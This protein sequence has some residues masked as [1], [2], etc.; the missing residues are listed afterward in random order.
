ME[1][2]LGRFVVAVL[3][4][5]AVFALFGCG[6][7]GGSSQP[8]P[9][10]TFKASNVFVVVLEN[11]GFSSVIGNA[12]MP[13]L[14]SLASSQGLATNYFANTHPSIGNQFMLT[15]GTIPT[16]DDAFSGTISSDNIVRE[17]TAAG[18]TW[19]GY[20][21]SLPS[22]GYTG[23]DVLPYVKHHNPFAYFSDVLDS[24]AQ[25]ANL[26][27][28]TQLA[29]DIAAGQLPQFGYII[30]NDYENGHECAPGVTC[31]DAVA[32]AAADNWLRANLDPL[33]R[34]AAFQQGGL[35]FIL[36]DESD[37][38]DLAHGGGHIPVVV[39]GPGVKSAF[40]SGILYQHQNLLRTVLEQLGVT[41]FPGASASA[42]PMS[43]FFK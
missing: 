31:N 16:N 20:F 33:I 24:S 30:P 32:L 41:V 37:L 5:V 40:Q 28:A 3:A 38:T 1:M 26:V 15:T 13:Y 10:T 42:A 8:P 18:K 27:P 14:N 23:G 36:F 7:A 6:G 34:S 12:A 2:K 21:D 39:V 29:Q 22:V 43:D 25:Q 9:P 35:L 4:M 11:H 17:L 19:K